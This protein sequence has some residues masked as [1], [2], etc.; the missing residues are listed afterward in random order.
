MAKTKAK[1]AKKAAA[2]K[3]NK[4]KSAGSKNLTVFY[5]VALLCGIVFLPSTVLLVFGM[6]PTIVAVFVSRGK[7]SKVITIGAMNLAGCSPFLMDL[8]MGENNFATSLLLILDPWAIMVMYAAAGAGYMLDWMT[9]GVVANYM[10]QKAERR[11]KQIQK[12]KDELVQ[13]WGHEV[14][15]EGVV[16]SEVAEKS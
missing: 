2:P 3:K 12:R 10:I 4:K 13:R 8:W 1:T 16:K 5:A 14:A 15:S 7:I 9:E 6:L 11:H